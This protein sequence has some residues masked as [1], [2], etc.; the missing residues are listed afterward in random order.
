[1]QN[2][3]QCFNPRAREGRDFSGCS[4]QNDFQCFNPRAREG[5]DPSYQTPF[6]IHLLF[7]ST[8]PRGAR[9]VY[10]HILLFLCLFQSTR[11]RGARHEE[12]TM[13]TMPRKF[14]STRPRGARHAKCVFPVPVP[15][16]FNPRAREGRDVLDMDLFQDAVVSIHAPARGATHALQ[17]SRLASLFQS[18][19]PR[20]AR[21]TPKE[22]HAF[23]VGFNPRAREGRDRSVLTHFSHQ[24]A[25]FN[26]RAR[27]GRDCM[28]R[29]RRKKNARFNP[30]AREGRDI[31]PR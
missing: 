17:V 25:C 6:V 3:F 15:A 2:D 1:M 7:Q 11:P 10:T 30:R 20:G 29:F 23:L 21:H 26:P 18:T 13:L 24:F 28:E 8:R 14:Q 16:C 19:R 22:I 31:V 27:E 4:M 9:P 5:R 12:L